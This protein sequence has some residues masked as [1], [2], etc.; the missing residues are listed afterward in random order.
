MPK[1]TSGWR[2]RASAL[3]LTDELRCEQTEAP[4]EAEPA[5]HRLEQDARTRGIPDDDLKLVAIDAELGKDAVEIASAEARQFRAQIPADRRIVEVP[6]D[7]CLRC[8]K[9][10]HQ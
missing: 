5:Q 2:A 4:V 8:A 10:V 3:D 7:R 1:R 6:R 9:A